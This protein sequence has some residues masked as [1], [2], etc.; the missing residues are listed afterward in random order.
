LPVAIF[1]TIACWVTA[2]FLVSGLPGEEVTYAFLN[3]QHAYSVPLWADR[4]ICLLIYLAIGYLL[5]Q[6]NNTFGLIRLRASM[7]TSVFLLL[8]AACPSI[9]QLSPDDIA[10]LLFVV[11][12]YLLFRVYR[13]SQSAGYLFRAFLLVGF[14]S[15]I[16]PQITWLAPV[17]L[18][19]A[20]NIQALNPRSLPA[21]LIGWFLPYWFLF[22]YAFYCN[23]MELLYQPFV[24]LA[25][26]RPI[27]FGALGIAEII[28]MGYTFLL[29]VASSIH[30]F[31]ESYKDKIRAR[32]HLR[33]LVLLNICIYILILLQ[34]TLCMS[35]L[36]LSLVG[37]SI[38]AGHLFERTSSRASN[39]FFIC[40]V[41]ILIFL[42][43]F[44]LWTLL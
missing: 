37:T 24:E 26:L 20:F 8:I 40:S 18:V 31:A 32:V 34:P 39:I 23:D 7:Q 14:G 41:V 1:I 15:L 6:M 17:L 27:S 5:I 12:I 36:P 42:I 21:V 16:F 33:F 30:F 25:T 11:A 13:Q 35:L 44:N 2:Y 3:L 10:T 9:Q 29:F 19:G 4:L 43:Y 28:I 38:L 22:G